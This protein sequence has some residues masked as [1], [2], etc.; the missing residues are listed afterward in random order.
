MLV[1]FPDPALV[2]K[3]GKG[4]VH[5]ECILGLLSACHQ[6]HTIRGLSKVL[7]EKLTYVIMML[8]G[9]GSWSMTF[10]NCIVSKF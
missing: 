2:V 10:Y 1:S 3:E 5:I 6:I 4:L 7:V 9:R 8:G